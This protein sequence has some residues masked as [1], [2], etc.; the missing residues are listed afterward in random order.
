MRHPIVLFLTIICTVCLS[1]A[2]PDDQERADS[3]SKIQVLHNIDDSG[4][5]PRGIISFDTKKLKAGY[6]S[7]SES[8]SFAPDAD[9]IYRIKLV[10]PGGGEIKTGIRRCLL[11]AA[12]FQE[13]FTIHLDQSGKPFHVDYTVPANSCNKNSTSKSRRETAV[14]KPQVNIVQ[15]ADGARP[16]Y[17]PMYGIHDGGKAAEQNFLQKYWMYIIPAVALMLLTGGAAEEPAAAGGARPRIQSE[18][19]TLPSY[20][21]LPTPGIYVQCHCELDPTSQQQSIPSSKHQQ[22]EQIHQA[23]NTEDQIPNPPINADSYKLQTLPNLYWC[24]SCHQIKCWKCTLDQVACYFCPNCLFEVP[25]ASVKADRNMCARN[26]FS[27][28]ICETT[29][30]VVASIEITEGSTRESTTTPPTQSTT[31]TEPAPPVTHYLSCPTCHWDSRQVNI[32]FEKPTGLAM[33][34]RKGEDE[35]PDIKEFDAL[36]EYFDRIIK[37]SADASAAAAATMSKSMRSGGRGTKART[38]MGWAS[39]T[40]RKSERAETVEPYKTGVVDMQH[41]HVDELDIA[42]VSTLHQRL[43]QPEHQPRDVTQLGP[44]RIKLRTKLTRRCRTCEHILIKPEQ[45]ASVNK[46][47]VK[48][49]ASDFLPTIT[50]AP[51]FPSTPILETQPVRFVL[52]FANPTIQEIS[53]SLATASANSESCDVTILAPSFTIPAYN[54]LWEYDDDPP[55]PSSYSIERALQGLNSPTGI[56]EKRRNSTCIIV[57]VVPHGGRIEFPVMVSITRNV[58]IVTAD[59]EVTESTGTSTTKQTTS[60]WAWVALGRTEAS[61]S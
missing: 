39:L 51:P 16:S 33:Q 26:C 49:T 11:V 23:S 6:T 61:E 14:F 3:K 37:I 34:L 20:A 8:T 43:L 57:Q 44:R 58:A 28:P 5:T 18:I 4:F 35:R 36:K 46:L 10:T 48:L 55:M 42:Q 54:E 29:L 12:G 45:K 7:T 40:G 50:I 56:Y 31:T 2:A 53:V 9:L 27:C 15:P 30:A 25:S 22:E 13:T 24:D 17:T 47:T 41:H 21:L 32:Q 38:S 60:Y 19:M 1:L 52:R 59:S